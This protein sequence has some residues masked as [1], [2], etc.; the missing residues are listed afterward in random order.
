MTTLADT[1]LV[2]IGCGRMGSALAHGVVRAGALAADRI[3][4]VDTDDAAA[5]SLA[6]SLGAHRGIPGPAHECTVWV[7]AVKPKMVAGA[8]RAVPIAAHDVV[9]SVA[10]GVSLASLAEVV[11]AGVPVVRAMPNTPALIGEGI[12]GVLAPPG[13]GAL[14]DELF[15]A[16]GRV[17]HL[18]DESQFD[19]VTAVSGSGPAY[20]FVAIEA[21][22]D[23]G[24]AM[25]LPRRVAVELAVQTVLGAAALARAESAHVAEL[26][27]RV[28]SPGGTTIAGLAA[29]ER[30]GFRAALMEAVRAAT[31]RSRELG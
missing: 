10:A 12:T 17:V 28:A 24:V 30:A 27:D 8:L 1:R 25:G 20:V 14:A 23:G 31:E 11:P 2:L 26:K 13:A 19:A 7:V 22:A 29:L 3:H 21:L 9:V 6:G 16:V 4:C 15:G 18:D 5:T